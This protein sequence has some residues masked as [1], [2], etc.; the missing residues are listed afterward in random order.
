MRAAIQWRD[1]IAR[2][3][4][5]APFRVVGDPVLLTIAMEAPEDLETLGAIKGMSPRLAESNGREILAELSR[6][7]QMPEDQLQPYPRPTRNGPGRLTPEEEVRADGLRALRAARAAELGLEKGVLLS[8]AQ[9]QEIVRSAPRSIEAL[10][11]LTGVRLWQVGIL[12][13]EIVRALAD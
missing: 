2:A 8:N 9:I 7:R 11:A 12:G 1:R 3:R 4:D 5:R 13:P 10:E 6:I